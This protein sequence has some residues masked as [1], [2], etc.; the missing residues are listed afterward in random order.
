MALRRFYLDHPFSA[1]LEVPLGAEA[2]QHL[3]R[4]L[5][6]RVGDEIIVFNGRG[7]EWRARVTALDRQAGKV[8]LIE[9]VD[10]SRAPRLHWQLAQGISR[11]ERMDYT[12]QKAVEL[13]VAE[14]HPLITAR[15]V[16]RLDE[17]RA[18]KRATHW[19]GVLTSACE[20][21]GLN[22]LP[23]LHAARPID[24]FFSGEKDGL[25]LTLD[26]TAS[27]SVDD[28][29]LLDGKV[30]LLVGP[31]GGLDDQ[32]LAEAQKAGFTGIRLGPRVLRTETAALVAAA[33]L[34][35]KSGDLAG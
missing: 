28:L 18:G 31:E 3:G 6:A 9:F 2:L 24:T 29:D 22:R 11:G 19:Q 5:R 7:G 13:G 25:K 27:L 26:P 30:T 32:E 16:V 20:Q 8:E 10:I 23:L 17:S 33:L 12:L 34:L 15:S 4:V 35:G 21:S 1:G 14:V